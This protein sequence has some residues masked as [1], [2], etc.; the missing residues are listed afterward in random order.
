MLSGRPADMI[1]EIDT[2]MNVLKYN[3]INN[4]LSRSSN[5]IAGTKK[6]PFKPLGLNKIGSKSKRREKQRVYPS[7][8]RRERHIMSNE[9][10]M[11]S[12]NA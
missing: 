8:K 11:C 2:E 6:L 9:K 1:S 4:P 10:T 7:S 5:Y 3:I 12:S